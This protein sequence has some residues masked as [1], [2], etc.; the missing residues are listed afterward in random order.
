MLICIDCFWF[1]C[2]MISFHCHFLLLGHS[3]K[4]CE[5]SLYFNTNPLSFVSHA[6]LFRP[7][8]GWCLHPQQMN[9][10]VFTV[11]TT[12]YGLCPAEGTHVPGLCRPACPCP[13][14]PTPN[15]HRPGTIYLELYSHPLKKLISNKPLSLHV[16]VLYEHTKHWFD[17]LKW[18]WW[19]GS[20]C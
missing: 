5:I 16:H 2:K 18:G 20:L 12:P 8:V 15:Q 14:C 6:Y 10:G 11:V 4:Y 13:L 7:K 9:N 1:R 19:V 3:V 17:V